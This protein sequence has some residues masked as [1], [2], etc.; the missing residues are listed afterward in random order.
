VRF[1]WSTCI[2]VGLLGLILAGANLAATPVG[3][4]NQISACDEYGWPYTSARTEYGLTFSG[5]SSE[6][7]TVWDPIGLLGNVLVAVTLMCAAAAACETLFAPAGKGENDEQ[8]V[9]DS[10]A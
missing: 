3:E 7:H 6:S 1:H 4:P 9:T 10:A 5:R 8:P 2:V